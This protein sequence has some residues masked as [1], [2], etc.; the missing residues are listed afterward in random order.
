M[1]EIPLRDDPARPPYNGRSL[2]ERALAV[3][4]FTPVAQL[5]TAESELVAIFQEAVRQEYPLFEAA[6]DTFLNVKVED[7]NVSST[8]DVRRKWLFR[9]IE[10]NWTVTLTQETL[11][12]EGNRSGYSD[13]PRF[14]QRLVWLVEQ[15]QSTAKPTHVQKLGVRYLNTGPAH[16]D[17]DPRRICAR[18]L[19]SI[20]GNDDLVLADLFWVLNSNEGELLLRSG[21][22][23]AKASYDP[24]MFIPRDTDTWY[25]DIDVVNDH[26]FEFKPQV[27]ESQLLQQAS[28][29][30]AVY[31]WA[32]P[33]GRDG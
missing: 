16:G 32:M 31:Y 30:H 14:I 26:T 18:Q 29:L 13:W 8:P 3:I 27:I 24:L 28:R 10:E 11:A 33:E 5:G 25:L 9:D 22:M 1:N 4:V 15:L 21:V 20:T 19:T 17:D 2:L 23:P 6:I 7:G 12:L